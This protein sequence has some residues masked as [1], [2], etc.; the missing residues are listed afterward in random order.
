MLRKQAKA[1]VKA[2]NS[3]LSQYSGLVFVLDG[4]EIPFTSILRDA[5]GAAQSGGAH[6]DAVPWFSRSYLTDLVAMGRETSSLRSHPYNVLASPLCHSSHQSTPS[7]VGRFPGRN[8]ATVENSRYASRK[9][10]RAKD[11]IR[12]ARSPRSAAVISRWR[13]VNAQTWCLRHPHIIHTHHD[14]LARRRRLRIAA[15][16]VAIRAPEAC[17]PPAL[18]AI[19][20]GLRDSR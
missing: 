1:A 13:R 17:Q 14:V 7:G 20:A 19:I 5:G 8:V 6:K 10:E 2:G 11:S 16:C 15:N 12:K 4:K 3:P 18:P 9:L